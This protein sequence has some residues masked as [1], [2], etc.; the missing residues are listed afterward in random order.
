M[1]CFKGDYPYICSNKYMR[2]MRRV[3]FVPVKLKLEID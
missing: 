3:E 1:H 2:S